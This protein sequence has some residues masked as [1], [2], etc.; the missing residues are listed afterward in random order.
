MT[1]F[2]RA[3]DPGTRLR[4]WKLVIDDRDRLTPFE[5]VALAV[6]LTEIDQGAQRSRAEVGTDWGCGPGPGEVHSR[7]MTHGREIEERP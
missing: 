2:D 5:R 7:R 1:G 6:A 4:L 3:L